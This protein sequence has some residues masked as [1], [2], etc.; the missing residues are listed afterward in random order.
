MMVA[1]LSVDMISYL[2]FINRNSRVTP[3]EK[4]IDIFKGSTVNKQDQIDDMYISVELSK[5]QNLRTL[6]NLNGTY[7]TH[8]IFNYFLYHITPSRSCE[9]TCKYHLTPKLA[10]NFFSKNTEQIQKPAWYIRYRDLSR[11]RYLTY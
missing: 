6:K 7:I 11:S 8:Y 3:S 10:L 1:R 9:K 5:N 2:L 4:Y